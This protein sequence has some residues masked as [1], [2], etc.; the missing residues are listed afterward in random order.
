MPEERIETHIDDLIRVGV[1]GA[2]EEAK[3]RFVPHLMDCQ[4]CQERLLDVVDDLDAFTEAEHF[5]QL[6]C[7]QARNAVLQ[8]LDSGK[9]LT[10]EHLAHLRRCED[11]HDLFVEPAKA[12]RAIGEGETGEVG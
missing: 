8:L 7:E 11:C 2:L 10:P 5:P 3:L 6:T 12:L 4:R 9:P 1:L